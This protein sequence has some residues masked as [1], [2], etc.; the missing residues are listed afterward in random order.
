MEYF[1]GNRCGILDVPWIEG[2]VA[3]IS[4]LQAGKKARWDNSEVGIIKHFVESL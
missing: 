4:L 1:G 3:H 2:T